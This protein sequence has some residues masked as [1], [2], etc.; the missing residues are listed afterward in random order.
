MAAAP[1][2]ACG[3]YHPAPSAAMVPPVVNMG[4]A[5][6]R[7][8]GSANG[9]TTPRS[10]QL[11]LGAFTVEIEVPSCFTERGTD[12][13]G[14]GEPDS[15][16]AVVPGAAKGTGM[17]TPGYYKSTHK[18]PVVVDVPPDDVHMAADPM[19]TKGLMPYGCCTPLGLVAFALRMQY[20]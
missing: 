20:L 13:D 19:L 14:D 10:S 16:G 4:A 15:M 5:A 2:P 3:G 12:R 9:A 1:P 6:A 18:G 7:A 17:E 11:H 8:A